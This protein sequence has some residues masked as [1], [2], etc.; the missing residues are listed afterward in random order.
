MATDFLCMDD[1]PL[2]N[3]RSYRDDN[4]FYKSS[5]FLNLDKK[6]KEII[7]VLTPEGFLTPKK[8]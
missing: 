2:N 8:K 6:K 4:Y 3:G 1:S 7:F 5:N